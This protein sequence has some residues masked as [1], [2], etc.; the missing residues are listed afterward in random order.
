M[1]IVPTLVF[2][3]WSK[4]F[5]VHVNAYSIALG[6]VLAQPRTGNIVHLLAFSRRK[7]STIDINY[8]L[9]E[10]EGLAMVYAL[11]KFS[12]YLLGGHFKMFDDHSTLKYLVK[13]IVLGGRILTWLLLF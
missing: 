9:T 8:T 13:N 12:H 6:A 10:R 2:P 4:E 3:Y 1:V 5:H 11:Q 7:L